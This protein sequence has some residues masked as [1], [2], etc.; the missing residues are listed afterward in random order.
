M[1]RGS[2]RLDEPFD[3]IVSFIPTMG[4]EYLGTGSPNA[5]YEFLPV[6]LGESA[7]DLL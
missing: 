3:I 5:V 2:H 7:C 1:C 4:K 6:N